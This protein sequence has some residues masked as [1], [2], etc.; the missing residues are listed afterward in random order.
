ML[1]IC[2]GVEYFSINIIVCCMK[3]DKHT[4]GYRVYRPLTV[5]RGI[6]PSE[7]RK[8]ERIERKPKSKT[9]RNSYMS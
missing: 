2:H 7:R 3:D 5:Y 8:I 9:A 4:E 1:R 6:L